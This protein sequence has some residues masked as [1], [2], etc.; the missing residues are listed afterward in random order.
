MPAPPG[1]GPRFGTLNRRSW[2]RWAWGAGE[3][4]GAFSWEIKLGP[5]PENTIVVIKFWGPFFFSLPRC[6]RERLPRG[7]HWPFMSPG[8]HNQGPRNAAYFAFATLGIRLR[9]IK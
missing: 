4:A 7:V 9:I 8:Y 2:R 3:R 5:E 1:E 6:W